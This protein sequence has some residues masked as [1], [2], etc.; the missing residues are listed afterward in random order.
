M[1]P[2]GQSFPIGQT[3]ELSLR[4]AVIFLALLGIPSSLASISLHLLDTDN[5][6][7]DDANIFF[8]YA[9]N[10]AEGNGLI[11]NTGGERVEG[12]SHCFGLFAWSHLGC[13]RNPEPTILFVNLVFTLPPQL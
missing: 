12:F 2:L 13:H 10:L 8:V 9:K 6:G 5:I 7:V 1:E 3:P 4:N 11:Y